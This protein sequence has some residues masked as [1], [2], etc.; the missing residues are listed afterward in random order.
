MITTFLVGE[1]LK[2]GNVPYFT[3]IF[4]VI[5]LFWCWQWSIL[6][7]YH[8]YYLLVHIYNQFLPSRPFTIIIFVKNNSISSSYFLNLPR[9]R[10]FESA[11]WPACHQMT[12]ARCL[13]ST[14]GSSTI[15]RHVG[16]VSTILTKIRL[17]IVLLVLFLLAFAF[18]I[19]IYV[20]P[21]LKDCVNWIFQNFRRKVSY[22][23]NTFQR[24]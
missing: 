13:R 18:W 10:W 3:L 15:G 24:H 17:A 9:I 16:A 4:R 8:R 23:R 22:Q 21:T 5:M 12:P 14:N 19:D 7:T 1:M 20:L 2:K 6:S 11:F